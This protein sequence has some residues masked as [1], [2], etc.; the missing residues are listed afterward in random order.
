VNVVAPA[1][2][3]AGAAL[4]VDVSSRRGQ[5]PVRTA[6]GTLLQLVADFG[7]FTI[8]LVIGLIYLFIQHDLKIYEII[9]AFVL[10]AIIIGSCCLLTL[11]LWRVNLLGRLLG[12]IQKASAIKM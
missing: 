4:F 12:W 2:G 7:A 1:G 9:G 10:L 8:I 6:A 5:S 11:G 3:L